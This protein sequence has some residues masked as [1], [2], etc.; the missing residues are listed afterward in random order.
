MHRR[1]SLCFPGFLKVHVRSQAFGGE[2]WGTIA[3]LTR[4]VKC[5]L[6]LSKKS[7]GWTEAEAVRA[8]FLSGIEERTSIIVRFG[9]SRY[10]LL[11]GTLRVV[12]RH[13]AWAGTSIALFINKKSPGA[14]WPGASLNAE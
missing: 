7:P 4:V 9:S 8:F 12:F 3:R 2:H 6:V 14:K 13:F 1:I 10:E 11:A 5:G